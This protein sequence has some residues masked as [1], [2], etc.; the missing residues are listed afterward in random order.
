[1]KVL[2]LAVSLA[3]VGALPSLSDPWLEAIESNR[4]GLQRAFPP[5]PS[6]PGS[7]GSTGGSGCAESC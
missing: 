1:M 4:R 7:G 6:H 3:L 5:S 2:L